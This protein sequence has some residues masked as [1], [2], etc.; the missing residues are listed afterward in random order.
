MRQP[1]HRR[2][3]FAD[4]LAVLGMLLALAV[5]VVLPALHA[6]GE[7]AVSATASHAAAAVTTCGCGHHHAA[8]PRAA[9]DDAPSAARAI[10]HATPGAPPPAAGPALPDGPLAATDLAATAPAPDTTPA[11]GYASRAP[12]HAAARRSVLG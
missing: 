4:R 1:P 8:A 9:P 5:R 7:H 12:P 10:D 2:L 6:H 11:N 3:P